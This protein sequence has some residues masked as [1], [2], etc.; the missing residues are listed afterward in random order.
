MPRRARIIVPGIPHHFTQRGNGRQD[1]FDTDR[2]RH[3]F[4]RLLGNYATR[5][6]LEIWGYCLMPNHYHLI[7]APQRP[8]SAARALGRLQADYARYLNLQRDTPG[9]LWQARFFSR[10][11]DTAYTW[12]ALAYVE[13]NPVRAALA[14]TADRF[15]WSSAP[16]RLGHAAPP[17]WLNLSEWSRH[18]NAGDWTS[19]LQES[20]GE[21]AF[22]EKFH[23][24]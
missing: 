21:P 20:T 22:G 6:E 7:A 12:R 1:I 14:K 2:D 13:R 17:A 11:M 5:Y 8:D 9:H 15:P 18:W 24:N 19:L 23:T 3:M 10:P 4:L 16:F